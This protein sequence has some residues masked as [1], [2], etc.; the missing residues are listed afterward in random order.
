MLKLSE[1][2]GLFPTE[3]ACKAFLVSHR[4]PHG[5]GCPRCGNTKVYALKKRPFHWQ[6]HGC[7]KK[8]YRFSVITGTVFENTKYPLRTW[9]TV[10][11][12]MLHS[13]KGMSALQIK[14]MVFHDKASYETVWYMCQRIRA[15]MDTD[16]FRQLAGI[17][18]VDETF[19]GGKE[20]FK[21]KSKRNPDNRG[22]SGKVGV[23]GAIARKG[24]VVAQVIEQTDG[25]TL[26]RFVRRAV[27]P[28]VSLLATDSDSAYNQLPR[29]LDDKQETVN[30]HR[31]E[32]VR[33]VVHTQTIDSFWS[34]LKRGIVGTYHQV[35]KK[36]LPFYLAEFSFRHNHRDDADLFGRLIASC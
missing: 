5:V 15:A 3:D 6:C 10:A 14:R 33:G 28:K 21:H 34:L 31:E 32:Y 22:S 13:K 9:F 1:L 18:E 27:S 25:K 30:H 2:E 20:R 11:F 17:V 23:I 8:G 29:D 35:S 12:L 16:E 19:L 4:W 36:Y 7:A 24:K 26:S